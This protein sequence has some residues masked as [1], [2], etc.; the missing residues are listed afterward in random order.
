MEHFR[1]KLE[2]RGVPILERTFLRGLV[3]STPFI[4]GLRPSV[5]A[6]GGVEEP[7]AWIPDEP[8]ALAEPVVA[9]DAVPVQRVWVPDAPVG[10]GVRGPWG[11]VPVELARDEAEP[12]A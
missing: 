6:P 10:P 4:C 3:I 9:L 8:V 11:P 5:L 12:L 2:G 1:L 7:R